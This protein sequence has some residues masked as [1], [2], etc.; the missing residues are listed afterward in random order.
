MKLLAAVAIALVLY[1]CVEAQ[2]VDRLRVEFWQDADSARYAI[3]WVPGPQGGR[4]RATTFYEVEILS[5]GMVIAAGIT[6]NFSDTLAVAYPPLDSVMPLLARVRAMDTDGDPSEWTESSPF[7]LT[8]TKLPPSPPDSVRADTLAMG[9]VAI[10]LRPTFVTTLTEGTVQFCSFYLLA[11]GDTG[12][13]TNSRGI[14]RCDELY[15][16]WL[17]ERSA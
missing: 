1:A 13:T 10:F 3:S 15:A 16:R 11:N 9:L 6:M 5:A 12:L 4:Q 17:T 7:T 14:A 8:A 2:A